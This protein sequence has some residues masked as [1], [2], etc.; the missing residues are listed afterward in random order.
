MGICG[1]RRRLGDRLSRP[2]RT[3]YEVH[4]SSALV[5]LGEASI[6][7]R[8]RG[9]LEVVDLGFRFVAGVHPALFARLAAVTLLPCWVLCALARWLLDWGWRRS[10]CLP[11]ALSTA[12]ARRFH[13]RR[14]APDVFGVDQRASGAQAVPAAAADLSRRS[15][16][17]PLADRARLA[18]ASVSGPWRGSRRRSSTRRCCS[19]ALRAGS[20]RCAAA[21]VFHAIMAGARSSCCACS[22]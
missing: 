3:R 5:N 21:R 22:A 6:V 8:R 18:R 4:G 20:K 16:R 1:R 19:K 9:L 10:G 7:V 13:D 14:R 12:G 15:D 11:S 17:D 2:C